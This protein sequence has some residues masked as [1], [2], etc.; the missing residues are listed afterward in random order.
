MRRLQVATQLTVVAGPAEATSLGNVMTHC[1]ASKEVESLS[2][3]R[4]IVRN[5]VELIEFEPTEATYWSDALVKFTAVCK[6]R[7]SQAATP[8]S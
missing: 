6:K 7:S 1:R 4:R 2:D 3:I 5:S 8:T